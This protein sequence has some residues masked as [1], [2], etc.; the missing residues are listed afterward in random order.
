MRRWIITCFTFV[1]TLSDDFPLV[2]DNGTYR[3]IACS[4][5]KACFTQSDSHGIYE[6]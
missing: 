3:H 1:M 4:R 5:G 2:H 6:S